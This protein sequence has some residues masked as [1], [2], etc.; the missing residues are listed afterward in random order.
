MQI[1]SNRPRLLI[2]VNSS[3]ATGFLQGQP[4]NFQNAGFDVTVASP[5]RRVGEWQVA[6]PDSV[7][8]VAVP[9]APEISPGADI[10]SAR[11][12]CGG[13]PMLRP[14][15]TNVGTPTSGL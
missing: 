13:L 12:L 14:P 1:T 5:E 15:I 11:K 6:Q 10:I 7:R 8:R 2:A 4:E 3:I 9:I